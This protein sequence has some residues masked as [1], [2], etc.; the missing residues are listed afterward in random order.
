[1]LSYSRHCLIFFDGDAQY[2]EKFFQSYFRLHA[3]RDSAIVADFRHT[4]SHAV[5][6]RRRLLSDRLPPRR[7]RRTE[8]YRACMTLQLSSFY[9]FASASPISRSRG[10]PSRILLAFDAAYFYYIMRM[11]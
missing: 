4:Y 2:D 8:N 5:A 6:H 10:K 9:F 3:I 11:S 7:V 1:M